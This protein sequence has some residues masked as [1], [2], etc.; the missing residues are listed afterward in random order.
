[1]NKW[2]WGYGIK[3][4]Y[5]LW[6]QQNKFYVIGA[7]ENICKRILMNFFEKLCYEKRENINFFGKEIKRQM[8]II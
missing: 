7:L 1:M 3:I 5:L 6:N 4:K 8:V 2:T